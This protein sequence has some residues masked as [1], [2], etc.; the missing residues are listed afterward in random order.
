M[1]LVE[2]VPGD[3]ADKL[4]VGDGIAIAEHHGGDLGIEHR[5]RDDPGQMPDDLDVLPRGMEDLQNLLVGHE[6]EERLE[7]DAFGKGIHDHCFV[8]A[9]ELHHAEQGIVG[10][11]AQKLSVDG[12][13]RVPGEP[14]ADGG[15]LL[16]AGNQFHGCCINV[17]RPDVASVW[18]DDRFFDL[19]FQA[20]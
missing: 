13:E 16:G 5:M 15:Q 10:R 1:G 12:D 14:R 4:I 19:L 8:G 7:V 2:L 3:A 20:I 9:G 11:L 18:A 6:I 17:P